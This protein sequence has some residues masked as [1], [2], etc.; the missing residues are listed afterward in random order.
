MADTHIMD[1]GLDGMARRRAKGEQIPP[2]EHLR[3]C[4]V[5]RGKLAFLS[6]FYALADEELRKPRFAQIEEIVGL[7]GSH[8]KPITLYPFHPSPDLAALGVVEP[9]ILLAAQ[10]VSEA[11]TATVTVA[12][13]VSER[14]HAVARVTRV[15]PGANYELTIVRPGDRSSGRLLVSLAG[16]PH[17]IPPLL[18]DETGSAEFT[19]D[20]QIGWDDLSVLAMPPLARFVLENPL[21]DGMRLTGGS[22]GC[23]ITN[24]D[25]GHRL[26]V[27]GIAGAGQIAIVSS[28]ARSLVLP[29]FDSSAIIPRPWGLEAREILVFP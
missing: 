25:G 9:S 4:A 26:V 28:T 12:T 1:D 11:G 7:L 2:N 14:D 5:C 16:A 20:E 8:P 13:F 18:T 6:R 19:L 10:T 3:S 23:L 24:L 29:L 17:P 22:A 15:L 27:E 21:A